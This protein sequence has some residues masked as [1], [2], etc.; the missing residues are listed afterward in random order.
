MELTAQWVRNWSQRPDQIAVID[1]AAG[2]SW[3]GVEF[4]Q[5]T[6]AL[7]VGLRERGVGA[8]D[9]VITAF[10]PSGLAAAWIVAVLRAGADAVAMS[11]SATESERAHVNTVTAPVLTLTDADLASELPAD[12]RGPALKARGD[13]G[14]IVFTSGTTGL[15]KGVRHSPQALAQGT[16]ALTEA[17][18]W[19]PDDVLVS[20]L[21]LFHV[22]GLVVAL[23]SSFTAGAAIVIQDRFSPSATERD[24]EAFSATMVFGVPTMWWRIA[25]DP[26]AAQALRGLRLAVSGSAALDRELSLRLA[27][28]IGQTPVERYGM[29]ETL[30]LTSN[31]VNG[32]RKPGGVG[33][34]LPGARVRISAEGE[35][36]VSGPTVFTGYLGRRTS[37]RAADGFTDDGWFR[38]GDLGTID[39]DG[40]LHLAGRAKDTIITGGHNV[41][42]LEVETLLLSHPGVSE[43][44]IAGV[45]DPQWGQLI[46][47][48]IVPA[49]E[50][51]DA[52]ELIAELVEL[53][54]KELS[55][56]KCPR[57]WHPA[58]ELPRNAMGKLDRARL[59]DLN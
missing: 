39:G 50:R 14:L 25:A 11:P 40:H 55:D 28:L 30:I 45:P 3:T 1:S 49:P 34:P 23:F 15:P 12:Q 37:D 22:H 56:F 57:R 53:C 48:F 38:T 5:L 47:A 51:G 20:A 54:G 26:P 9:R 18:D 7:A 36:E 2:R 31:P 13:G 46:H 33:I 21:P 6:E 10:R 44:A 42:P 24:V 4:D 32:P 17:W 35:V 41:L 52:D 27:G 59:L 8:G 16:R 29:T 43:A 58:A 19:T